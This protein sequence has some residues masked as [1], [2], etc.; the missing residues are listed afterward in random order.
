MARYIVIEKSFIGDALREVGEEVEYEGT[1][2]GTNL[3]LI[4]DVVPVEN[5][6]ADTLS[7]KNK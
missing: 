6:K 3:K 7:V 5:S 4:E 1:E 2:V